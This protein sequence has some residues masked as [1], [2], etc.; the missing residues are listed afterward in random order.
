MLILLTAS[1]AFYPGTSRRLV[2]WESPPG[3]QF[4]IR[5]NSVCDVSD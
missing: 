4:S 2:A 5:G 1:L 3:L